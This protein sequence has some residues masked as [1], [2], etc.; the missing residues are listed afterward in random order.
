MSQDQAFRR[1]LDIYARS[2]DFPISQLL[3]VI[4]RLKGKPYSLDWSHFMFEPFFKMKNKP[5]K[6]VVKSGRQVS[7]STSQGAM[8]LL[9]A[10]TTPYFNVLTVMPLFEQVRKFSQNTV[11]PF[12]VE[13][14]YKNTIFRGS[15]DSVL[16]RTLVNG[17]SLFYSYTGGTGADRMRGIQASCCT[18]DELQDLDIDDI[19]IIES[20]MGAS[21]YKISR[22]TGTPKSFDN[23]LQKFWEDSSQGV[24]HI[25]CLRCNHENRCSVEG[26]L[27]K[28]IGKETLVCARCDRPVNSRLGYYIHANPSK[29]IHFAG[30]HVP[31]VILPM[32]YESPKD[33]YLIIEAMEKKPKYIFYN[34]FLGESFDV[35]TKLITMHDIKKA[36]IAEPMEPHNWQGKY[37]ITATGVDWGGRGKEKTTDSDEFI[38][39]TAIAVAG[40]RGDGV[41]EIPWMYRVPYDV[42]HFKETKLAGDVAQMTFSR[43]LAMDYGGQGNVMEELVIAAGYPRSNIVPF[44]YAVNPGKKGIVFFERAKKA[45]VRNSYVLDKPRSLL[46]LCELIKTGQVIF[47][48]KDEYINSHLT[49]FFSIYLEAKDNPR[50]PMSRLVH[51]MNKRTDDIVHAVNFAVMALYH[52]TNRWPHLAESFAEINTGL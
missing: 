52:T 32:H 29:R 16:Q 26:D 5:R 12:I 17:S 36:S 20:T 50:G 3:P 14:P 8:Q 46:L 33:W 38:S 22:Y 30:Y 13:S 51:R 21:P 28:M 35:G 44:S 4:F 48:N 10:A 7:K 24:W 23:P 18:F 15:N 45:G 47:A 41:I 37:F 1:Y 43:W 19:P 9:E 42:D 39:N 31:Q 27:I 34:E 2:D 6:L 49:D 40:M 11:R 25:P